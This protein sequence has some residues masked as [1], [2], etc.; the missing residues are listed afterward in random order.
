MRLAALQVLSA[1]EIRAIH[2]ATLDILDGCGVKV[3]SPRMLEALKSKGLRVD[4]E[5][6][7]AFFSRAAIEEALAREVGR[8]A[9][10]EKR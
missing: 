3:L 7:L 4:A 2:Q 8:A 1:E 9:W 6:Q 10:R 5:R